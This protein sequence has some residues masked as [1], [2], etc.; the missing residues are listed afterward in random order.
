MKRIMSVYVYR[1]QENGGVSQFF[2][3][4]NSDFN[5][6]VLL[7]SDQ[8]VHHVSSLGPTKTL[9]GG[10]ERSKIEL[11]GGTDDTIYVKDFRSTST[12]EKT[13]ERSRR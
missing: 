13:P 4:C 11:R 2:L 12:Q 7:K 3:L 5:V 9:L 6:D 10:V 1:I 8:K